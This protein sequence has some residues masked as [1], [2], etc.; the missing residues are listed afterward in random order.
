MSETRHR[1]AST[2]AELQ[3]ELHQIEGLDEETRNLLRTAADEIE[4]KLRSDSLVAE[5]ATVRE[6]FEAQITAFE[7]SHPRL[8]AILS[9]VVDSLAQ[10]GV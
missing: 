1:L 7:A 5:P 9:R 2:L 10:L 6:Q 8:T 3:E 4:Q